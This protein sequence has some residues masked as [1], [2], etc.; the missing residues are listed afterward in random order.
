MTSVE[1]RL[2]E[3]IRTIPDFPKPGIHF[4]DITP[5]L[6]DR[7]AFRECVKLI[8]GRYSDEKVDVVA[9]AEARGFILGAPIA[10]ELGAGFV[11]LR[12]PGKLPY[13]TLRQEYKLEY[14]TDA[15]EIH[16]DAIRPGERVLII[17]DVLATGGTAEAVANLIKRMKGEVVGFAFLI[18]IEGLHGRDRLKDYNV[19]SLIRC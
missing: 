8:A 11:P 6:K 2:K 3:M 12:K 5:L 15:F 1:E 13:K 17:D 10:M 18:E 7:E 14:G 9:A 19:Y 16:M 4:K